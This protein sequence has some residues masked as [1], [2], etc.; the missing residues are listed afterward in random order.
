[1]VAEGLASRSDDM[2]DTVEATE[3]CSTLL[4]VDISVGGAIDDVKDELM[5]NGGEVTDGSVAGDMSEAR[6]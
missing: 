3:C 1:M 2:L 6:L 5:P 4:L